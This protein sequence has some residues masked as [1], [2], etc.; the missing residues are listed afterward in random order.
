[1]DD[2]ERRRR[3]RRS[4]STVVA[5]QACDACRLR[6]VKCEPV[7]RQSISLRQAEHS[8]P[9][10][11]QGL[12]G[13][14]QRCANLR[15][16][17]T[18][19]LPV[20]TRGPRRK[21]VFLSHLKLD[22]GVSKLVSRRIPSPP[23]PLLVYSPLR[24]HPPEVHSYSSASLDPVL[25][26][27]TV[28]LPQQHVSPASQTSI[29]PYYGSNIPPVYDHR[30]YATDGICHRQL[31]DI[32]LNDFLELLYPLIPVV[33]RPL[34]RHDLERHRDSYDNDFLG[35]IV[36][37]CAVLVAT[38]PRKFEEYHSYEYPLRF[39]TRT[40]MVNF[41]WELIQSTR[42]PDYFD[43]IGHRKWT[44]SYLLYLAYHQVG[45]NNRSRMF[46]VE[47]MQLA[48]LLDLHIPSSY[49]GLNC[50]E[51]QLRKKAFWLMIYGYV[52][53]ITNT[54]KFILLLTLLGIPNCRIF[55]RKNS[56]I[57]NQ[58]FSEVSNSKN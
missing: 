15:I 27:V 11:T 54:Y 22:D 32:M 16:D 57:L 9:S 13:Q 45:Q 28:P 30:T 6:K 7:L 12:L 26:Q 3:S 25:D 50:I 49:E 40:E 10:Q 33:H 44:I 24:E 37:L 23:Q 48:R 1:M 58:D 5:Q 43:Q 41:C 46:E 31:I 51:T 14:C 36:A 52:Q 8:C 42:K 56:R 47:A 35:V 19:D 2:P 21:Y 20:K 55:G 17:C 53:V 18:F 39:Q 38:I 34:F 4:T 29:S